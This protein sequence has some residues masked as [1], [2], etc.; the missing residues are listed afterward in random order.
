M[1]GF[2]KD[3]AV[4]LMSGGKCPSNVTDKSLFYPRGQ[5]RIEAAG[6]ESMIDQGHKHGKSEDVRELFNETREQ[7]RQQQEQQKSMKQAMLMHHAG[8]WA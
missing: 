7:F 3:V 8:T 4:G 1:I 5:A 2:L 6:G